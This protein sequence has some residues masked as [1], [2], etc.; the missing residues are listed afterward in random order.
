LTDLRRGGSITAG[1]LNAQ[2]AEIERRQREAKI[3]EAARVE[4]KKVSQQ[5]QQQQTRKEPSTPA[6]VTTAANAPKELPGDEVP[7]FKASARLVLVPTVVRDR[8]GHTVDHLQRTD[9]RLL[10]ERKPQLIT[11][12]SLERPGGVLA[13]GLCVRRYSR[14]AG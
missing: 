3:A 6:V 7:V 13:C 2:I 5:Q 11:Q 12:F 14:P 1:I 4:P 10:D 9:F 8:Q